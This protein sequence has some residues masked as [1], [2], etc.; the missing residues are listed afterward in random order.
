MTCKACDLVTAPCTPS[1]SYH[2]H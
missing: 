1:V 2:W